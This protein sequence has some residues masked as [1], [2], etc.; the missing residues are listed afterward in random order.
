MLLIQ[1]FAQLIHNYGRYDADA[2]KS[3]C[4]AKMYFTGQSHETTKE[5]ESLLG[6]YEFTGEKGEKVIRPLMTNDEIRTIQ[7]NKA[8]LICGNEKPIMVR[9]RPFYKNRIFRTYSEIHPA[10]TESE[11]HAE[12]IPI[13]ELLIPAKKDNA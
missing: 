1:D 2:I 7:S 6:K 5:L 9:L 8:L 3:N 11:V 10:E 12:E 4:F 13:L